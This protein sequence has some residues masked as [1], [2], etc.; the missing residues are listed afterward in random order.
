MPNINVEE[1]K[2]NELERLVKENVK[3][4]DGS[5]CD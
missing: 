5:K 4:Y 1:L 2:I 3:E